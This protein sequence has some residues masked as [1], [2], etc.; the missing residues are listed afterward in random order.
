[1][2][3]IG[4]KNLQMIIRRIKERIKKTQANNEA[5]YAFYGSQLA[6]PNEDK[7]G[8]WL[9]LSMSSQRWRVY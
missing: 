7:S 3:D 4:L 9:T 6:E 8:L 5:I 2:E 1:M